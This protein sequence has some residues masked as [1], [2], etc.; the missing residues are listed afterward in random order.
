MPPTP[1]LISC[2]ALAHHGRLQFTL[3]GFLQKVKI[4]AGKSGTMD[5]RLSSAQTLSWWL[6]ADRVGARRIFAHAAMLA[7]LLTRYTFE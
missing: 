1:L 3:P 5:S 6:N 4:A 2:A 7:C